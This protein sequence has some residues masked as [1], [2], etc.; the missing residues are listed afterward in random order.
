METRKKPLILQ[1]L[2]Q[3]W[4]KFLSKIQTDIFLTIFS[5]TTIKDQRS[6]FTVCYTGCIKKRGTPQF[7]LLNVLTKKHASFIIMFATGHVYV[8]NFQ[9]IQ[10]Q[11][12]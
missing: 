12:Q 6:F 7:D 8:L 1:R 2:S 10:I 11:Q 5:V 9:P 3:K 4:N